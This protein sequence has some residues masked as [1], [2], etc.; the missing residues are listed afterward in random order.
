MNDEPMTWR[1]PDDKVGVRATW[2]VEQCA[3]S[4]SDP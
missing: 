1:C 4:M 2:K 3:V